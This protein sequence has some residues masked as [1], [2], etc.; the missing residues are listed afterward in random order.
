M[1]IILYL[2][3]KVKLNKLFDKTCSNIYYQKP[4]RPQEEPSGRRLL[5]PVRGAG[6]GHLCQPQE[7]Q[8]VSAN[9]VLTFEE[10]LQ[11]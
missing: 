8:Q 4:P 11:K 5:R 10:K 3:T 9:W 7:A 2:E 6:R 1:K